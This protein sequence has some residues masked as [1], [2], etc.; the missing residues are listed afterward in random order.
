MFSTPSLRFPNCFLSVSA[1]TLH[2]ARSPESP[3]RCRAN[4]SG[5]KHPKAPG[6]GCYA[7]RTHYWRAMALLKLGMT[8]EAEAHFRDGERLLQARAGYDFSLILEGLDVHAYYDMAGYSALKAEPQK[9]GEYLRG[10][11]TAFSTGP[12][13]RRKSNSETRGH[14]FG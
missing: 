6:I 3:L 4:A 2:A 5:R 12:T 13:R 9:C 8:R 14:V 10:C 7:V 1:V 11:I